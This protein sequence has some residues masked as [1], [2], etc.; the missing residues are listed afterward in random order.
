MLNGLRENMFRGKIWNSSVKLMMNLQ[1]NF[2][3][4]QKQYLIAFVWYFLLA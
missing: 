2:D 4:I 3:G 1:K